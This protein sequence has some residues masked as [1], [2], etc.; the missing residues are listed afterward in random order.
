MIHLAALSIFSSFSLNLLLQFALGTAGAAGDT[1]SKE[2]REL[3]LFQFAVFFISV[4]FLWLFFSRML[5]PRW[6]GFSEYFLF[7]PTSALI[8]IGLELLGKRLI[9]QLSHGKEPEPGEIKPGFN[10]VFSA[11][12]A[13]DGL[14]PVSL[15]ITLTLAANFT[16]AFIIVLFFALGSL[17]AMLVL[18][19]IRRRSTME[20]VPHYLR[21]SPLIL[22]SMG[23]LSL[24][25]ASA[26]GLC[27]KILKVF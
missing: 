23:L 12:T 1:S 10:K 5:P 27:F 19:E 11:V 22:I 6:S 21:G 13:Y 4:L 3:P 20:W 8:C 24:I 26:A 14:V 7:F 9:P 2:K 16:E 15:F 18:Y 25:S 17:T